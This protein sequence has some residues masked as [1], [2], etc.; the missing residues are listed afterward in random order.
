MM[1]AVAVMALALAVGACDEACTD[2]FRFATVAVVDGADEP[3]TDATVQTYLVRTGELVPVTSFIPREPGTYLVLDDSAK[4]LI[5]GPE[6]EF[7]VEAERPTGSSAQATF[8]FSVPGGCHINRISG[9]D[10]L[11]VP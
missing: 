4:P 1:R 11:Q 2:E 8:V 3:V 9:P 10:T 6:E 5:E 7:R